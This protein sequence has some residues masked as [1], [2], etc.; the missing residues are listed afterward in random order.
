MLFC[1]TLSC[2]KLNLKWNSNIEVYCRQ[3]SIALHS[4]TDRHVYRRTYSFIAISPSRFVSDYSS[5]PW[6]AAYWRTSSCFYDVVEMIVI[7]CCSPRGIQ[8]QSWMMILPS[9]TQQFHSSTH[10]R[11]CGTR[12]W[13]RWHCCWSQSSGENLASFVTKHL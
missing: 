6:D 11:Q 3:C 8:S 9:Q 4:L 2:S 7:A 1:S 12:R 10:A 5:R 13:R